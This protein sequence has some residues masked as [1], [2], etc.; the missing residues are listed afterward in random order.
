MKNLK[1]I[2]LVCCISALLM[3]TALFGA[4]L[5]LYH[6]PPAV[7]R[8]IEKV[9]SRSTGATLSIAHLSYSFNPL[10][11]Q[12]EGIQFLS[13][14]AI[15]NSRLELSEMSAD[16]GL[17][18]SFG[19]KTL[20]FK[21]LAVDG[22][23]FRIFQETAL[24]QIGDRGGDRSF[25]SRIFKRLIGFFL[26]RDIAFQSVDLHHGDVTA[27]LE[28]H[29]IRITGIHANLNSAGFVEISSKARIEI[30]SH[31]VIFNAPEVRILT[32]HSISLTKPEMTVLL[33]AK[34][35]TLLSPTMGAGTLH[36][37]ATLDYHRDQKTIKLNPVEVHAEHIRLKP[38]SELESIP[39]EIRL[40]TEGVFKLEDV[41][42]NMPRFE[43][44]IT[45]LA[46]LSG[47]LN[48]CFRPPERMEI[49][50]TDSHVFSQKLRPLLPENMRTKLSP[51]KLSGP[52]GFQGVIEGSIEKGKWVWRCDDAQVQLQQNN[53]SYKTASYA[54]DGTVTGNI[55]TD[56]RF[57][58]LRLAAALKADIARF[59]TKGMAEVSPFQ[60]ALTLTG[61]HPVY[62]V[63][64][65]TTLVPELKFVAEQKRIQVNHIE[66]RLEKGVFDA[67]RG[68][69]FL[70]RVRVDSSLLKNLILSLKLNPKQAVMELEAKG[71]NLLESAQALGLIPMGSR[72]SGVDS[73]SLRVILEGKRHGSFVAK[74]ALHDLVFEYSDAN[75]MG[76]KLAIHAEMK[77]EMDLS[78]E[79]IATETSIQ[80]DRGEILYD[81]F[82][83]DLNV[84]PFISA[85]KGNYRLSEK[86]LEV[87][88]LKAG[89]KDILMFHVA[90]T[91][92]YKIRDQR[93]QFTLKTP[94]IPLRP[95][96]QHVIMEPFQT[97]KP[98]LSTLNVGGAVSLDLELTGDG[99]HWVAIGA[100]A[101]HDGELL[102]P[103][104]GLTAQGINLNLPLWYQTG[105]PDGSREQVLGDLAIQAIALPL[106]PKQPLRMR[107]AAGPNSLSVNAPIEFGIPGGNVKIGPISAS[108]LFS[109]RPTIETSLILPGIKIR[110][111]L[112]R[113]W[114]LPTE[115]TITGQLNPIVFEGGTVTTR[116]EITAEVFDGEVILTDM[117]ASGIFSASPLLG[118]H[119]RWNDLSLEKLTTG[120]AFGKIEGILEG[121][122]KHLE[123]AYGQPQR[124]DLLLETVKKRDVDQML[125]VRAVENIAQLGGGQSPF[126]GLAG[127]F[128]SFFKK[129]P[130]QKMGVHATLE[131]DVFRVN[132]TILEGGVEYLVKRGGLSG[133][134][135][136]NQSPNNR[137]SFKDMVKRMKRITAKG[138]G[139][140]VIK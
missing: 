3:I 27:R 120:T 67:D 51:I 77:G 6:H 25:T 1:K 111:I 114:M 7:K 66:I 71:L 2:L 128:A 94:A 97:E 61:K 10:S 30:P 92:A 14:G 125:S 42:L 89:L 107:L 23:S 57:P 55:K 78:T 75:A 9:I 28:D 133:V 54:L 63:R 36:L 31:N 79:Y 58:G 37:T 70:P 121:H 86:S 49:K 32:A 38:G 102:S 76:E 84:N 136:V 29:R 115:G 103:E 24:F 110:P 100:C 85:F 88:S 21:R 5:Y 119:A 117:H 40:R 139:E 95:V 33:T 126:M 62:R 8:L 43:I 65:F 64:S 69:F 130:Y 72:F 124:F 138:S 20:M 109:L 11:F 12:A 98:F 113:F 60:A 82:Y 44:T 116:G 35:A 87:S 73:L 91:A 39:L 22:F 131:N 99:K 50:L 19:Y 34:K 123:I 106:L 47:E 118:L 127:G 46:T 56:G 16:M 59:S 90:G 112:S 96:F 41:C 74:L 93:F 129:F 4:S 132:G 81:R 68:S 48:G 104:N 134:N 52:V 140:P 17:E 18:G 26:F 45:D 108:D 15:S 53:F 105:Q 137:I 80:I 135:I 101:W 122:V 13:D 83:V